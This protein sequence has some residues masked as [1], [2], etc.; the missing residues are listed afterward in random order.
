MDWIP[1]NHSRS[2]SSRLNLAR[3]SN[4]EKNEFIRYSKIM[5]LSFL[6]HVNEFVPRVISSSASASPNFLNSFSSVNSSPGGL[7]PI[8]KKLDDS[9]ISTR[10]TPESM[11]PPLVTSSP[12]LQDKVVNG[13]AIP[14]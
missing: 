13:P 14:A 9:D 10:V 6:A 8:T 2:L 3:T 11:S 1:Q 4:N 12:N 5:R 7:H